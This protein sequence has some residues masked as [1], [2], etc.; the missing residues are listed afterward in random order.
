MTAQTATADL[1]WLLAFAESRQESPQT[2]ERFATTSEMP[3]T[4]VDTDFDST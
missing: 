2:A 4:F 1:H 3:T